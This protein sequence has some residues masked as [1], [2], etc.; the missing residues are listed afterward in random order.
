MKNIFV[1]LKIDGV[2]RHTR[3][4][5]LGVNIQYIKDCQIVVKTLAIKELTN[6]HTADYL[7]RIILNILSDY[8]ISLKQIYSITLVIMVKIC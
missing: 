8:N 3:R 4:S 6:R 5:L 1:S 7:K 2:T